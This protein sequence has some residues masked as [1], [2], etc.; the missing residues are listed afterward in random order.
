MRC[1]YL[2]DVVVDVVNVRDEIVPVCFFV[3]YRC[4]DFHVSD[5]RVYVRHEHITPAKLQFA[6]RATEQA[7]DPVADGVHTIFFLRHVIGFGCLR[8]HSLAAL[9]MVETSP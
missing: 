7:D 4:T 9:C 3:S 1:S 2:L 6:G 5:I 8:P